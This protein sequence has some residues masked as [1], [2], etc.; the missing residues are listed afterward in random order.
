MFLPWASGKVALCQDTKG[1]LQRE[2]SEESKS[3]CRV[4]D[5][6]PTPASPKPHKFFNRPVLL[7]SL[8]RDAATLGQSGSELARPRATLPIQKN[9]GL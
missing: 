9:L 3:Q 5:S 6:S 8:D 7:L 1:A 2:S 4:T